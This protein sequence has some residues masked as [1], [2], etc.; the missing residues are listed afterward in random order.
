MSDKPIKLFSSR[1]EQYPESD[2]KDVAEGLFRATLAVVPVIGGPADELLS[3]VLAPAVQV[4]RDEWLKELDD[5]VE[6]L[7]KRID[8]F[9]PEN[10][11]GNNAFISATIYATRIALST[12]QKEKRVLLRNALITIALNPT[13][14]EDLQQVYLS[15]IEAF[16]P[17][18]VKVLNFLWKGSGQLVPPVTNYGQAIQSALPEL[19]LQTDFLQHILNDLRSRGFSNLSGPSAAHPQ[20]PAITNFGIEFLHFISA[21]D[22]D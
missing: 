19:K 22:P 1:A 13:I 8:G 10:L 5:A 16:T 17:S 3:L 11:S 7:E 9:K 4:R 12:H 21:P 20:N 6:Q 14:N 18:H 15:A 2:A